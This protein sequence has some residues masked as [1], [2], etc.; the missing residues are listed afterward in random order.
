MWQSCLIVVWLLVRFMMSI[1]RI[2]TDAKKPRGNEGSCP[3]LI[4]VISLAKLLAQMTQQRDEMPKASAAKEQASILA[5]QSPTPS[6]IVAPT[7]AAP[8]AATSSAPTNAV[9][10]TL[11][12]TSAVP[13]APA[14][15]SSYDTI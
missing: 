6:A 5:Q 1:E 8:L 12:P 14:I 2:N 3:S 15:Q 10:T 4:D 11:A 13:I 7:A 9:P